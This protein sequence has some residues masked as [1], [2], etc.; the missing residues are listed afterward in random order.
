M[1]IFSRIFNKNTNVNATSNNTANGESFI[2]SEEPLNIPAQ[3]LFIDNNPPVQYDNTAVKA[4]TKITAFLENNFLL[5]GYREG[6]EHHN[7]EIFEMGK[8]K[9]LADFRLLIDQTIESKQSERLK[10]ESHIIDVAQVCGN[11][12]KKLQNTL[13]DLDRSISVLEKQKELTVDNEGWVMS[14]IHDYHQGFVKGTSDFL[15]GERLI[16]SINNL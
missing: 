4:K 13:R 9:I 1:S 10:L 8:K 5:L 16:N 11:T 14:A 6:F 2:T 7:S 3:D 12:E 15:E